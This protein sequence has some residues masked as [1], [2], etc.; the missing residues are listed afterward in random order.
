[1]SSVGRVVLAIGYQ[2]TDEQ[3]AIVALRAGSTD[4]RLIADAVALTRATRTHPKALGGNNV[5]VPGPR[6]RA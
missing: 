4:Q 2:P 6:K 1:V 3:A 5:A